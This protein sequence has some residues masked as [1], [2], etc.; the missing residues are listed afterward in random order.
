MP[1]GFQP[2]NF[3]QFD[4]KGNL[5]QHIAHFIETYNNVG[6]SG[7]LLGKQ[8]VRSLKGLAFDWYT[9]LASASIDSW[10]QMEKEFLNHFYSTRCVVSISE[11]TNTRQDDEEPIIDY[12]NRW[13][14]LSLKCKDNLPESYFVEMCAQGMEWNILYVLQV[15]KPK[16]FQELATQ[17]HDMEVTI[18][19]YGRRIDDGKSVTASRSKGSMLR[20]SEKNEC[21]YSE[22]DALEILHKLLEKGLIELPE[23]R[24]HKEIGRTNDPKHYKYHRIFSHPIEKYKAFRGQ[25]LQLIKEGKI[26]LDGEDTEES[27]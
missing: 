22:S 15:N 12:I 14:A 2:L 4:G 20:D 11:L 23:L 24:R 25:V 17:A 9:D 16:T 13:R 6:T 1:Q 26:T 3:H 21:P 7:D 19:Y 8:F 18:T 5:K 27:D 10:G